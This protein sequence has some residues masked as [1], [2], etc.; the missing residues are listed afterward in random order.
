MIKF[1]YKI[2][3]VLLIFSF[4][5]VWSPLLSQ[6]QELLI[7]P[8][9]YIPKLNLYSIDKN[10]GGIIEGSFNVLNQEDYI[11]GNLFYGVDLLRVVNPKADFLD[12]NNLERID[13]YYDHQDLVF[14]P[15][16]EKEIRFS[17]QLP[18]NLLSGQYVVKVFLQNPELLPLAW[19]RY[20]LGE[21]K[22]SEEF[23]SIKQLLILNQEGQE[24]APHAGVPI[25]PDSYPKLKVEFLNQNN[26]DLSAVYKIK[27]FNKY[28]NGGLITEKIEELFL[29][30]SASKELTVNLLQIETPGVYWG[31]ISVLKDEKQIS[32]RYD[33]HWVVSGETGKIDFAKINKDS[34]SAGE[35]AKI[36]VILSD[37]PDIH[38][39]DVPSLD[40]IDLE[41]K[42][43]CQDSG[44]IAKKT[45]NLNIAPTAKNEFDLEL[46][47][48]K[49]GKN[50]G[51]LLAMS[52]E[53]KLLHSYQLNSESYK[54][55]P[56]ITSIPSTPALSATEGIILVLVAL[57]IIVCII[58]L[59][60]VMKKKEKPPI[61]PLILIIFLT[62]IFYLFSPK[63]VKA[64]ACVLPTIT[65]NSPIADY[66]YR[67]GDQVRVETSMYI[68]Y[69]LNYPVDFSV[70][71]SLDGEEYL[72]QKVI[73]TGNR[74]LEFSSPIERDLTQGEHRIDIN[75]FQDCTRQ[76][77][78]TISG[79]LS[80][81]F[82]VAALPAVASCSLWFS[83]PALYNGQT[84]DLWWSSYGDNDDDI[85][86]LCTGNLDK[87][88]L[89][90]RWGSIPVRPSSDQSCTA[91][92][93]D[94]DGQQST[95]TAPVNVSKLPAIYLKSSAYNALAGQK[96]TISWKVLNANECHYDKSN[97]VNT[98]WPE[99]YAVNFSASKWTSKQI[100]LPQQDRSQVISLT[101]SN[102]YGVVTESLNINLFNIK[103]REIRP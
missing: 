15:K 43:I 10:P 53:G 14:S 60:G 34:F 25:S 49:T 13:S 103:Y 69:C 6:A 79:T 27:F 71:I 84:T 85:P 102:N 20:S 76:G 8:S 74:T 89:R 38:L 57:L 48:D 91:T 65:W 96:I 18:E 3:S 4:G 64:G 66:T 52:K 61:I 9:I 51:L 21:I 97:P 47:T 78:G 44:Q 12:P 94:K 23:V 26:Q 63:L 92:V 32:P 58:Y 31:E 45:F 29:K 50:C 37:R 75:W 28:L 73:K 95:C 7:T 17:Y 40:K 82:Y 54:I 88:I 5:L 72:S 68:N 55:P 93:E 42:L 99:G 22:G 87:G 86:Y 67:P 24:F 70:V 98:D 36:S 56:E 2:I 59:I 39:A 83:P 16:S 80:R 30:A 77:M 35:I 100:I 62:S 46:L 90:G 101:C 33:F 19:N 41:V 11:I 81:T 1:N